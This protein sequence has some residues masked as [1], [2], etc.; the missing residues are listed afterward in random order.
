MTTLDRSLFQKTFPITAA[1]VFDER[2]IKKVLEGCKSDILR[3]GNATVRLVVTEQEKGSRKKVLVRMKPDVKHDDFST[4]SEETRELIHS[5]IL[6]LVPHNLHMGYKDW[7]YNELIESILPPDLRPA[8]PIHKVGHI[9][10]LNLRNP[11]LPYKYLLANLILDK[12]P[13]I[14]TVINKIQDVGSW[15]AYR[16]FPMELL[17]GSPDTKVT[18]TESNCEFRFDFAKVYWNSRLENEHQRIIALFKPGEAVADVM[19]G[20]GPFAVPAAKKK[21]IVWANDINPDAYASLTEG[22]WRN[23]VQRILRPF[24]VDAREFIPTS[25]RNLYRLSRSPEPLNN[26]ITCHVDHFKPGVKTSL[27]RAGKTEEEINPTPVKIRL[28]PTFSHFIMNLPASAPSYLDAFIGAYNG[29]EHLFF[30]SHGN[31]QRELPLVHCYAFHRSVNAENAGKDICEDI[32]KNL[33]HEIRPDDLEH[34]ENV[35][36]VAPYKTMWCASFRVPVEVAFAD[37]PKPRE[38]DKVELKKEKWWSW[39]LDD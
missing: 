26:T 3:S 34:L 18:T 13:I 1:H 16:T 29:L 15:S 24:N 31:V 19:A 38:K 36:L 4:V 7:T 37:V 30:D 6:E 35:R 11:C 21:V 33:G 23:K 8:P 17:A 20:A 14:T 28:P 5:R 2:N 12:H 10:H 32:S 9:A 22:I 39:A 27:R 25:I